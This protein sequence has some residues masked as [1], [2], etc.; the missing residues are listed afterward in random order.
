M[1]GYLCVPG[2]PNVLRSE[3]LGTEIHQLVPFKVGLS[4]R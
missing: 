3:H 2:V 4:A 1:S